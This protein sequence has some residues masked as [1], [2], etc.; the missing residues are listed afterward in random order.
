MAIQSAVGVTLT[1]RRET[2]FGVLADNDATARRV[3][4]VSHTLGLSK[5]GIE[6]EEVR[7]SFQVSTSRHGNRQVG[8]D[9]SLQLQAGTYSALMEAVLRR[10][11]TVV[12]TLDPLT[13]VV[14]A[15]V[16]LGG[17]FTRATGSWLTAGLRVGMCIRMSGW[18]D[19]AVANNARNYTIVALTAAVMTVAEAVV[20]KVAGD[21]VVVSVPGKVTH[22]PITGHT[23][24]S[25]SFEEWNPDVPRSFRFVGAR[26]NTMSVD[27]TPNARAGLT[28]GLL[29]RDRSKATTAYFE[30]AVAAVASAMQVG[31]QGILVVNGAPSGVITGLTLALTN[32]MEAGEV[33]GSD[34][35]PDV[36]YNTMRVTGTIS[37]YFESAALDDVF[38]AESEIAVI[39]RTN[40]DTTLN[41]GFLQFALPRIKLA[42]GSFSTERASRVQSFQ[43]TAL[44]HDGSAGN[45][46]T[47]LLVQDSSL[48]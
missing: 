25:F 27:L 45:L 38:D 19:T 3:P 26:V 32:G 16:A 29:G 33:V 5:T 44:E 9:L 1:Y 24:A 28:F 23:K 4:Y 42:G 34:L 2:T 7:P 8:G 17:T 21:S 31:H 35:T 48:V 36:F 20:A 47:T 40:D 37:A 46:A 43:F 15:S 13:N 41:S 22:A 14:A 12:T 30:N 18:T 6:S 10:D 11:F 39:V